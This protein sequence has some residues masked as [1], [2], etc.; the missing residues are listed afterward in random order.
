MDRDPTDRNDYGILVGW[1]HSGFADKIN[2]KLQTVQSTRQLKS[3]ELDN[4]HIVMT[5]SQ[6]VLLANYLFQITG[7]TPPRKKPG[8]IAR[9]CGG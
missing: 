5:A 6:A 7:Q 3:E 9:L 1:T 4:H 2:L 8:R